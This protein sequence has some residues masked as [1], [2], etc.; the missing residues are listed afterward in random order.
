VSSEYSA[1]GPLWC[2]SDRS[3]LSE[4]GYQE[5]EAADEA[6]LRPEYVICTF[7]CRCA[8]T[9]C[10]GQRASSFLQTDLALD[11]LEQALWARPDTHKP[12]HHSDGQYPSINYT[13]RLAEVGFE[14]RVGSVATRTKRSCRVGH[15]LYETE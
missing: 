1:R 9:R 15:R 13:G 11:A 7:R 6:V 5:T 14:P 2:L 12:I 4:A 8:R 10:P 3:R